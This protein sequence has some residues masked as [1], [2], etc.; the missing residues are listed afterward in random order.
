MSNMP[1]TDKFH[2]L[3]TNQKRAPFQY[4]E[5]PVVHGA[6]IAIVDCRKSSKAGVK[7][8]AITVRVGMAAVVLIVD[9]NRH[10]RDIFAHI[11]HLHGYQTL[12]ATTGLEA[13]EKTSA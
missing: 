4:F 3:R 7:T 12:E 2:P 10:I 1:F 6:A 11:L 9:D 8:T 5:K 13:I